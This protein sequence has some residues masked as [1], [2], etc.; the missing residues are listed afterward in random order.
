M[1]APTADAPELGG[2][3][4]KI[5]AGATVRR[6]RKH[7]VSN[8]PRQSSAWTAFLTAG[9][10]LQPRDRTASINNQNR[11]AA[12]EAI[13]QGAQAILGLGNTGS[14]HQAK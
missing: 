2:G 10:W 9:D 14:F 1:S 3:E 11:L 13:D 4:V 6:G 5:A 12:L 7:A 8:E